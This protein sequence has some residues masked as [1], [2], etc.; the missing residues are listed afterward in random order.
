MNRWK[1]PQWLELEVKE[2]DRKCVYCGVTM[3]GI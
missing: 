3:L 1:I 2:R